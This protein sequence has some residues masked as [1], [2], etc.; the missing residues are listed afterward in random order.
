MLNNHAEA[1]AFVE[2]DMCS[3]TFL[4]AAVPARKRGNLTEKDETASFHSQ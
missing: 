1:L 4:H 3:Q 2:A